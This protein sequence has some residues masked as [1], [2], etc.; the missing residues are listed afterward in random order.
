MSVLYLT[1]PVTVAEAEKYCSKLKLLKY[2]IWSTLIK[3]RLTNLAIKNIES[4]IDF[5]IKELIKKNP[6]QKSEKLSS[7]CNNYYNTIL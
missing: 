2:Y 3:N 4:K 5:E 6:T 1:L 7:M